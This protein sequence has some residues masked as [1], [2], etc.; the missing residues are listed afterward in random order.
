MAFWSELLTSSAKLKNLHRGKKVNPKILDHSTYINLRKK[1]MIISS[2][3]NLKQ[4]SQKVTQPPNAAFHLTQND[5]HLKIPGSAA[6]PG[7]TAPTQLTPW[8]RRLG[9]LDGLDGLTNA[10]LS[11]ASGL[12]PFLWDRNEALHVPCWFGCAGSWEIISE[13]KTRGLEP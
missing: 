5:P 4:K 11:Y 13:L 6:A 10:R 7:V 1:N 2:T 9:G 12:L 8:R 3:L